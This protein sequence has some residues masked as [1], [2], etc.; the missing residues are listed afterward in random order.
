[1]ESKVDE[2]VDRADKLFA[3]YVTFIQ[4]FRPA[5]L[6]DKNMILPADVKVYINRLE[7]IVMGMFLVS[8]LSETEIKD[9]AEGVVKEGLNV[10]R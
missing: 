7:G 9:V 4:T 3:W 10:K 6:K 8:N 2:K 5:S 1:M